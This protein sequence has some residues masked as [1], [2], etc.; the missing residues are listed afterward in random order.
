MKIAIF[1][2]L[3]ISFAYTQCY[4]NSDCTKAQAGTCCSGM[5]DSKNEVIAFMCMSTSTQGVKCL[6]DNASFE[7]LCKDG[8]DIACQGEYEG[9]KGS[10]CLTLGAY[11][12]M[13]AVANSPLSKATCTGP[14]VES[15]G[16]RLSLFTFLSLALILGTA[17]F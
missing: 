17:M 7:T 2:S 8:K 16:L 4:T 9:E 12:Q 11:Q 6:P 1:A 15:N 10:L 14:G 3:L 5:A 13:K